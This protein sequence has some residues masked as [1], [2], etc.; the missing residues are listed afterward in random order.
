[1]PGVWTI[2]LHYSGVDDT[3]RCIESL[4]RQTARDHHVIVVD[5]D[6]RD[7]LATMMQSEFPDVCVIRTSINLGWA[8][9]NNVGIRHVLQQGADRIVL[10]NNDAFADTQLIERLDAAGAAEPAFGILGPVVRDFEPPH[11]VQSDGFVFNESAQRGFF[12]RRNVPI[13]QTGDFAPRVFATDIV[14]GCCLWVKREVVESIGVIDERYFL[15]HEESDFCL[16][17]AQAGFKVGVVAESLVLHRKSPSFRE[18]ERRTGK[19]WQ[20]YFD[21]R[22]MALLLQ[23]HAR[24]NVEKRG[25][26]PSWREYL[27][28]VCYYHADAMD[29]NDRLRARAVSEGF[30]D[31]ILG[32]WGPYVERR[33]PLATVVDAAFRIARRVR[34]VFRSSRQ[35]AVL[36]PV[37][38]PRA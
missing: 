13:S 36:A 22:N 21:V 35:V 34:R 12:Q 1:M 2:V 16:R 18:A 5:N 17:A 24:N 10:F 7:D 14:M 27:I 31:A 8:G 25:R 28:Q 3:R 32:R 38:S 15:I 6:S 26:W 9:G 29:R 30:T 33:R 37:E 4:K 19:P 20:C 23:R 11:D